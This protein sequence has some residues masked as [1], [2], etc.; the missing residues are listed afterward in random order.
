MAEKYTY[1]YVK[2]YFADHNCEL[3]EETY[4]NSKQ[5]LKYKCSCGEIHY[6]TFNSFNRGHGC[7]K[8]GGQKAALKTKLDFNYVYNYYK[9]YQCELLE[10]QYKNSATPM[11]FKC[12][13]GKITSKKFNAFK[14]SPRCDE[15]GQKISV[16]KRFMTIDEIRKI[17][18][19]NGIELLTTEYLGNKQKLE[20]KCY[21]GKI[22]KRNWNN[23]L[24]KGMC[25]KYCGR[26]KR[27]GENHYNYRSD[28]TD[29]DRAARKRTEIENLHWRYAIYRRDKS[30]CRICDTYKKI[31]AHHLYGY[32]DYPELRYDIDNGI[33]LCKTHHDEFHNLYGRGK[34]TKEQFIEFCNNRM[35][36]VSGL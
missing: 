9:E 20:F 29:K 15:C 25:C 28:L 17:L 23:L 32:A 5:K 31:E 4:I 21:C 10:S 18:L 35:I 2:Q 16:E 14:Q 11:K 19:D 7:R 33:C 3:F 24:Y 27:S 1:E 6:T 36:Q 22:D 13:C 8:L 26:L 12:H 30:H 34:N